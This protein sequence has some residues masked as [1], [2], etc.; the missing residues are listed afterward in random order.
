MCIAVFVW[1]AHP[2]YPLLL[3]FNRDEYY[4]RP[5]KPVS[6]WEG[7]DILGGKD[8]I[9]GG[10]WLACTR[11]G[12]LAFLTNVLEPSTCTVPE[13]RSRGDLTVRFLESK[14]DPMEFAEEVLKE[15]NQYNGFNLVLCDLC[16]KTMV[17]ISNRPQGEA[18]VQEVSPGIHV[19]SNTNMDSSCHKAQ[20]LNHTFR[21]QLIRYGKGE[22]PVELMTA[23]LMNDT[24]KAEESSLPGVLS[25]DWE[26][27]TSS[28]YVDY[29][30]TPLGACGTRSTTALSVNTDDDISVYEN[31]LVKEEWKKHTV[32]F[33]ID[34]E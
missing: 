34:R 30:D 32:N 10:T 11:K 27:N 25:F 22:V 18:F 9:G 19:L 1:Q 17:Y 2:F 33:K 8:E 5:S 21:E 20:R 28:I 6:W 23:E 26:Y 14:K 7:R 12:K 15:A 13:A 4:E 16:S 29:F 3:L 31:Y 24:S